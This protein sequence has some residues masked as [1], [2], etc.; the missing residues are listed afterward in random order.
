ML[1]ALGRLRIGGVGAR[2]VNHLLNEL[3]VFQHG[4]G[5]E[6]VLVE[7]LVVMVGH[8]HGGLQALQQALL[9]DVGVGIVDEHAGVHVAVGVDVQVAAAAGD[10]PAHILGV[11]L[12]V[13]GK[14]A[15]GLPHGADAAVDLGP[16]LGVGHQLG[17][18]VVAHGH[19]VEEPHE[20]SAQIHDQIVKLLA[21]DVLVVD[22]GVAGGDAEGQVVLLQQGH[23]VGDL[24]V[25]TLSTAG[26]VGLLE[27]LQ[28]DG[29]D[30]VAHTQH[31]L[32]ELLV[33]QGGVG[34][35]E[36]SRIAVLLAQGDQV[37][38]A[39]QRLAAGVDVQ[40]DAQLLALSN[41]GV[42]LIKG[43]VELVAVLRRPTAGAMQITGG[44]GI[45]QDGPGNVAAV[46]LAQFLLL[47]PAHQVCIDKEVVEYRLEH[48]GVGLGPDLLNELVPTG[49]LVVNYLIK[50]LPLEGQG[51]AGKLVDQIHDLAHVVHRVLVQIIIHLG[52]A[53]ALQT[54]RNLHLGFPL[55]RHVIPFIVATIPPFLQKENRQNPHPVQTLDKNGSL[56]K[57]SLAFEVSLLRFDNRFL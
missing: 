37:L 2:L 21:G 47:G 23:G 51:V 8:E 44:G 48:T 36:E 25:H 10:A 52:Q 33:D 56:L 15:L 1:H 40:V 30:K 3:R 57:S 34:K 53:V 6:H 26:V 29:G 17:G 45:Q 42:N 22:A 13:H 55:S 39:H 14:D 11:V 27:A 41:D 5:A 16:L 54:V 7:G 9:P 20:V 32:A 43:Q 24:V 38:L 12:E 31:V 19:V 50:C 18:G 35:G 46:L 28:A 4:A 49:V